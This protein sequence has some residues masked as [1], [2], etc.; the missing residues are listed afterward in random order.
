MHSVGGSNRIFLHYVF[1]QNDLGGQTM[2][3]SWR[4]FKICFISALLLGCE[5]KK[6]FLLPLPLNLF[7]L[8]KWLSFL[9]SREQ[10]KEMIDEF[11]HFRMD[12]DPYGLYCL[13][14]AEQDV[15]SFSRTHKS[16]HILNKTRLYYY[17]ILLFVHSPIRNMIWTRFLIVLKTEFSC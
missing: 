16:R 15:I 12:C 6:P 10:A 8:M 11:D 9:W 13:H 3:S 14:T 1:L 2:F 7:P 5:W 17:V 4:V